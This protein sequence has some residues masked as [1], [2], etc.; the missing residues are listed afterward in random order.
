MNPIMLAIDMASGSDTA[1]S[2]DLD[3]TGSTY[4]MTQIATITGVT[5]LTDEAILF[6]S[7]NIIV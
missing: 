3:G 1:L 5:D 6:Y 7:G 2:V 4:S